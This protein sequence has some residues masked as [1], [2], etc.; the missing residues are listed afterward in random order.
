MDRELLTASRM[1]SLLTCPRKHYYK[2]E[3]GLV[4]TTHSQA[5]RFGSAFHNVMEARWMGLSC[6]EAFAK[7]I[8]SAEQFT[9]LDIATLSGLVIG[10]FDRYKD[11]NV[12][13]NIQPEVQFRMPRMSFP[14]K[15]E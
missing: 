10:Y 12:I 5:L 2:Y 7:G 13:A 6:E 4:A 14:S 3:I 11:D 9:E 15:G 1:T 8:E